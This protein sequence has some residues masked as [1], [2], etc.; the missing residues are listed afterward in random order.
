MG[1]AADVRL[2][3]SFGK[4]VQPIMEEIVL[5]A[6]DLEPPEP[7]ERATAALRDLKSGQYLHMIIPRRPRLLY[8]W[9][10]A[11]GFAEITRQ[12]DAALFELFIWP[13][14][15]IQTGEYIESLIR[16]SD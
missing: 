7:Y 9:L 5:D 1:Q 14:T 8:P 3:P 13:K 16:E 10:E 11:H 15:E 4:P 12:R 6:C 2:D